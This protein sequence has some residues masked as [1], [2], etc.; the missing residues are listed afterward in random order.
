MMKQ[1]NN[2]LYQ[3][4][5]KVLKKQTKAKAKDS[6]IVQKLYDYFYNWEKN[7]QLSSFV[8]MSKRDELSLDELMVLYNKVCGIDKLFQTMENYGDRKDFRDILVMDLAGADMDKKYN[9]EIFK[10]L[11][12]IE[13]K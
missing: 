9:M 6:V 3:N 7:P 13:N 2:S 12:G 8:F 4:C 10:Y 11:F 1:I 5:Y